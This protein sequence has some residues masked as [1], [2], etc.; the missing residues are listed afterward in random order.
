MKRLCIIGASGHGK[1]VADIAKHLDCYS[2]I[3]F[4][5]DDDTLKTVMSFPVIGGTADYGR[6]DKDEDEVIVAIGNAGIRRKIQCQYERKGY[7]MATL[8]HPEAVIGLNVSIGQGTVIMA[9]AVVN[10]DAKIGRGCIINTCASIDHDCIIK[11]FVHVSVGVHLAGNVLIGSEAWIGIG[12]TVS[13]NVYICDECVIG[14]GTV[15]IDKI[16]EKGTYVGNPA[17]KLR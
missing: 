9:G 5:D 7:K 1:V 8:A 15:V 13:N 11:D 10:A 14:A 4:L 16:E 12:S 17:R 3:F 2:E 6:L